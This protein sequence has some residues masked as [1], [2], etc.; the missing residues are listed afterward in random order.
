MPSEPGDGWRRLHPLTLIFALGSRLYASRALILPALLALVVSKGRSAHGWDAWQPWLLLPLAALLTLE[1]VHYFTLTYRFDAHDVVIARGILWT[2]ERHIPYARVQ[3]IELVQHWAHRLAGVAVV[4]LDTGTGAGA[5]AEL[6]VLSM[7]AVQELRDA[8]RAGRRADAPGNVETAAAA[9]PDVLAALDLRELALHGLLTSRGTVVLFALAGA[10]WQADL[11]GWGVRRYL[12]TWTGVWG[13]VARATPRL[14]IEL[15]LAV[16]VALLAFRLASAAWSV[17]KHFEFSL[18]ARGDE[19]F[20]SYGLITRVGRTIPRA[21]I[22]KLTITDT[23]LMRWFGRATLTVDTAAF[24]PEKH[25]QQQQEGSHVLVPIAPWTRVAALVRAVHPTGATADFA[26]FDALA[27]QPVDP[28]TFRRL[29]R[30]RTI[31]ALALGV[32]L[33]F[34]IHWWAIAVALLA[35][36][37]LDLL[38]WISARLTAFAWSGETLIFRS[39]NGWTRHISLVRTSRVQVVTVRQNPLDRR[40]AMKRV[41]V[42]TAGAAR[43]GHKIDVPWLPAAA[44]EALYARLRRAAQ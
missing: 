30:V 21:R 8:V 3:N 13:E 12:P 37:W 40:W 42:D 41:V 43:G 31:V 29:A 15:A 24:V 22:Q 26:D 6:A 36:A 38:A 4:R 20:Q 25:R 18:T 27:W 2:R 5:E 7:E 28:R 35:G 32:G 34:A 1:L 11:D 9:A 17:V 23:P 10:L 44:A 16:V 33:W 19:L 39:S 14:A